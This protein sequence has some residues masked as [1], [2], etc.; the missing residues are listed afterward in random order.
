MSTPHGIIRV[1]HGLL[2]GGFVLA[3]LGCAFGDRSIALTYQPLGAGA[4]RGSGVVAVAD[5]SD[6]RADPRVVGDVR[7]GWGLKTADVIIEGQDAGVWVA[8]A[9]A[10]ELEACGYTVE[11]VTSPTAAQ[12]PVVISGSVS[13]VFVSSSF[14]L[15][16]T[17]RAS[18]RVTRRGVPV[19]N[20]Q[21][22]GRG[23][24]GNVWGVSSEQEE[25]LMLG[26]QDL[27]RQ[28]LPQILEVIR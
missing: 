11:K 17:V 1:L 8:N 20:K 25:A 13:E 4:A 22:V 19:L 23:K 21:Y 16:S 26:L 6:A 27:T 24:K 18:I 15:R 2:L 14:T 7:N 12:A 5:L 3:S 10:A 28:A 9:L